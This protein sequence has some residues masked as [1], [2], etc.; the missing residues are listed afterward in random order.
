MMQSLPIISVNIWHILISLANLLILFLLVKK[1]LFKPVKAVLEKRQAEIDE[2][3]AAAETA[4]TA[5]EENRAAWE[6]KMA[7]ADATAD[8]TIKDAAETATRR[9]DKIV[10]DARAEADGIVRRAEAQAVLERQ[11]A[12]AAMRREI[13]EVSTQIAEKMLE[14]EI[15]ADDHRDMIDAFLDRIGDSHD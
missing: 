2:Q 6:D 11:N 9:A 7:S 1:F 10:A 8:Q 13:V 12:E 4:Q 5:A 14:R 3:Y 15:Q